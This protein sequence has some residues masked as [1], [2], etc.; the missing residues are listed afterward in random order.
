MFR[1][2]RSIG[3]INEIESNVKFFSG[4][5]L[6]DRRR[7]IKRAKGRKNSVEAKKKKNVN[8]IALPK[9]IEASYSQIETK[10]K[11]SRAKCS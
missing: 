8:Q 10:K 11:N 7:G 4:V 3:H 5:D 9:N 6:F 2:N 1:L